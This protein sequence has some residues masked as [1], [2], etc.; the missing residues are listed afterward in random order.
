MKAG[1][2]LASL[3]LGAVFPNHPAPPTSP[4]LAVDCVRACNNAGGS[5]GEPR[6]GPEMTAALIAGAV[7]AM[8]G[9]VDRQHVAA[10]ELPPQGEYQFAVPASEYGR[11][12]EV[13][14]A[15]AAANVDDGAAMHTLG[16]LTY[17]GV[18]GAPE[19]PRQS[20]VWHA[21]AAACGNLDAVAV[22]GGCV[23][24]G[25]GAEKDALVGLAL[26]RAA[27]ACSVASGLNKLG[28]LYEEGTLPGGQV[29]NAAAARLYEQSAA[30]GSALGLFYYGW[31]LYHGVGVGRDEAAGIGHWQKSASRAPDEGADEA[32]YALWREHVQEQAR[33]GLDPKE[34]PPDQWLELAADLEHP[35]AVADMARWKRAMRK[36]RKLR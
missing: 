8:D 23:R 35:P 29:D 17:A 28:V 31:A 11:R 20:A 25:V 36:R 13:A 32:A 26:I 22:L 14:V 15:A 27:A 18:G 2:L 6:P 12:Y 33:A 4:E 3:A 10:A 9:R 34:V 5:G 21:A 19:D 30:T 16:L 24:N 7:Q 1:A